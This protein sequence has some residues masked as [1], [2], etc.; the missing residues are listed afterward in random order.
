[1]IIDEDAATKLDTPGQGF[2]MLHQILEWI[3][4]GASAPEIP[5]DKQRRD[6]M[7]HAE[8]KLLKLCS[9]RKLVLFGVR[10]GNAELERIPPTV[11]AEP[12]WFSLFDNSIR[13]DPNKAEH[14][15]VR[16]FRPWARVQAK[17]EDVRKT[18]RYPIRRLSATARSVSL[19]YKELVTM[20]SG[21]KSISKGALR[22]QMRKKYGISWNGFD[23]AFTKASRECG[24]KWS[25]PGA[26]KK[27]VKLDAV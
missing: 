18:G 2:W 22:E 5:Q 11:F 26:P 16:R 4:F 21:E 24:G 15:F 19:C 10:S 27:H 17:E 23:R 20:M 9:A 3:A 12:V 25:K 13:A 7:Q 1:M 6:D 14:T 8:N